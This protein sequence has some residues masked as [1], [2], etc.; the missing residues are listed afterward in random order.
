MEDKLELQPQ[1]RC[2]DSVSEMFRAF[3]AAAP[4]FKPITKYGPTCPWSL[5][6]NSIVAVSSFGFVIFFG[7]KLSVGVYFRLLVLVKWVQFVVF[8]VIPV[9]ERS[10]PRYYED[11]DYS[12]TNHFKIETL[13]PTPE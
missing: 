10:Q 8:F 1:L 7:F 3:L 9:A 12:K 2:V 5:R 4:I 6:A 13:E 11:A